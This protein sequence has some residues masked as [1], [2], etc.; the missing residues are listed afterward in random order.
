MSQQVFHLSG[1]RCQTPHFFKRKSQTQNVEK[2]GPLLARSQ[3]LNKVLAALQKPLKA[4]AAVFMN[5]RVREWTSNR[6]QNKFVRRKVFK[7]VPA[8]LA[9]FVISFLRICKKKVFKKLPEQKH[10]WLAKCF[11]EC[12]TRHEID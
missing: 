7:V 2:V 1:K 9:T 3:L 8:L 5:R 11:R 4:A 10:G 6:H 12:Q